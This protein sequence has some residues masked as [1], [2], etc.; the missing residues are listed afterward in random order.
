MNAGQVLARIDAV[1]AQSDASGAAA[2]VRALEAEERGAAEQIRGGHGGPGRRRS[3]RPRR[4]A[5]A[6]AESASCIEQALIPP[7]EFET[8]PR[9]GRGRPRAGRLGARR[10]STRAAAAD[11]AARRVAQARAQQTRADDMLVQD[12]DRLA[13]R[14]HRQPP[15]RA[16]RRDGRDRHPEPA[17]HDADDHLGSRRDRRGSEGGRSRRPAPRVGQPATVTL[18]ALP[19]RR[20]PGRVVEIGASALPVTG[21][22]AAAREFKVVVRLDAAAIPACGPGSPAT[23]RS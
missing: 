5:A 14:R 22:G 19:G 8:R 2:Q 13:H 12:V 15:A 20:F 11:A 9:R 6:D 7:S 4:R 18:E 10:R 17:R 23:R 16:R 1:Q 21:T 3:A